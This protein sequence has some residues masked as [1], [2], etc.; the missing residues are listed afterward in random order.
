MFRFED[1]AALYW[2]IG[3]LVLLGI[4]L[5]SLKHNNSLLEKIG[6]RS[7]VKRLFP[8]VSKSRFWFKEALLLVSLA[9]LC[10]AW[11][12]PQWGTRKEKV[13]AESSDIFIG[14]DI[15]QSMMAADISP[16]R[17]ERSKRFVQKLI[18]SLRGNRIGLIFFAGGAYL[19]MPLTD[20]YAAAELFVRSANTNQAGSQ[21]TAIDEAIALAA[22]AFDEESNHQKAI[23]II[24]DGEDHD[25]D[26]IDAAAEAKAKGLVSYTVAVGTEDGAFVPYNNRGREAYKKDENGNPVRSRIN[27]SNM[28]QIASEGGGKFYLINQGE[29][30]IANINA[31]LLKLEKREV[32]QKSFSEYNSYFQY[33]LAIAFILLFVEYLMSIRIRKKPIITSFTLILF[34]VVS[35][36]LNAQS[37]H[38]HLRAGDDLY[39][40]GEY[41]LAEEAYRKANEKQT[42]AKST[43]NLGNTLYEQDRMEEAIQSFESAAS[44]AEGKAEKSMAYHNLGNAYY[45]AQKFKESYEAY[46]NALQYSPEDNATKENLLAAKQ[47]MKIQQQQQQQQQSS[48]QNQEEQEEQQQKQEQQ[49]EQDQSQGKDINN[50]EQEA[51]Q[52][53]KQDLDKEDAR[54]LLEIINNE[55]QKV[56]EKLRKAKAGD[57]KHKKD[58]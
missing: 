36:C 12:N 43:Y 41:S 52:E 19:Q 17:L 10:I 9:L 2:S 20:D 7:L 38:K 48:D 51:S 57:K 4:L 27:I 23:I 49:Q 33:F 11:S 13:K 35:N 18:K 46:K 8:A 39:E 31:E 32:E 22:K 58:W 15:S 6:N 53:E 30:A 50:Q 42:D 55:E 37:A 16:N 1:A 56:Q 3:V 25:Q 21:G 47:M 44:R 29:E 26:A 40:R 54:K 34:F 45:N 5:L 24:S 28:Q 14:L